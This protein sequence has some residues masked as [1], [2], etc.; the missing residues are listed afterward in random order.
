MIGKADFD[1]HLRGGANQWP[2]L[3][4]IA[5][6]GAVGLSISVYAD[7]APQFDDIAGRWVLAPGSDPKTAFF[8]QS[9]AV[10]PS[11]EIRGNPAII[12]KSFCGQGCYTIHIVEKGRNYRLLFDSQKQSLVIKD[13]AF[14]PLAEYIRRSGKS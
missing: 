4:A 14:E 13:D 10:L 5:A 1:Q 9:F 6:L 8:G 11:G 12:G 3:A 2:R 7:R